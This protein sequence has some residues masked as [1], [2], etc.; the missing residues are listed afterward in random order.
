MRNQSVGLEPLVE[1]MEGISGMAMNINKGRTGLGG[2]VRGRIQSG[3]GQVGMD[4]DAAVYD[5]TRQGFLATFSRLAGER[6]VLNEGDVQRAEKLLPRIGDPEEVA[7]NLL[8][9]L[10]Q[11]MIAKFGVLPEPVKKVGGG[12][13]RGNNA[14]TPAPATGAKTVTVGKYQVTIEP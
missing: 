14:A 10:R 11:F 13:V 3:K 12:S 6:G 8:A 9:Q 1:A 2:Y 7:R 5:R 4:N